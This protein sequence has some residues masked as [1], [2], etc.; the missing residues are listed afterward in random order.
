MVSTAASMF[1]DPDSINFRTCPCVY[2][3]EF[4]NKTRETNLAHG[5]SLAFISQCKS[6]KLWVIFV[7]FEA[8]RCRSFN[9]GNNLHAYREQDQRCRIG[10]IAPYPS[11]RTEEVSSTFCQFFCPSS[12]E[13]PVGDFSESEKWMMALYLPTSLLLPQGYA[14]A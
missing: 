5:D 13:V 2:H 8:Y 6:P 14:H 4:I 11:W 12:V 3:P 1:A 10:S 9:F 7:G